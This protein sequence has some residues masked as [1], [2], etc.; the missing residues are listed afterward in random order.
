MPSPDSSAGGSDADDE[1]TG[2]DVDMLD[3]DHNNNDK[4][5]T[6]PL[7]TVQYPTVKRD[8]SSTYNDIFAGASSN[9]GASNKR[10]S[11]ERALLSRA[12][13]SASLPAAPPTLDAA[14]ATRG[15]AERAATVA[16][17]PPSPVGRAASLP[18][19]PPPAERVGV[20]YGIAMAGNH[21]VAPAC[22]TLVTKVSMPLAPEPA[23]PSALTGMSA[24]A[25]QAANWVTNDL[26]SC[27][28]ASGAV[29]EVPD[30]GSLLEPATSSR[31]MRSGALPDRDSVTAA[32]N[33]S[34]LLSWGLGGSGLGGFG[35]L[36]SPQRVSPV[37]LPGRTSLPRMALPG[38]GG[39]RLSGDGRASGGRVSPQMPAGVR[40][41]NGGAPR[42]RRYAPPLMSGAI[43]PSG[44]WTSIPS[45]LGSAARSFGP[46]DM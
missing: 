3:C 40:E 45:M 43:G 30:S 19:S 31:S 21:S 14:D 11:T 42:G 8:T 25:S 4:Y 6:K 9:S 39:L 33:A 20:P 2:S 10:S 5:Y 13:Y 29:P 12:R 35:T 7:G 24:F 1:H 16:A 36:Q 23:A 27:F 26:I 46:T 18:V 34:E 44:Q 37:P 15:R 22:Q 41:A 32:L 28:P 38:D 17:P